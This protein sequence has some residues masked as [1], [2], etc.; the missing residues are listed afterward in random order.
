M[1]RYGSQLNHNL[2]VLRT[3]LQNNT[4]EPCCIRRFYIPKAGTDEKRPLGIP[5]VSDRIVKPLC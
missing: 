1:N 3:K 4:Y 2:K 5:T